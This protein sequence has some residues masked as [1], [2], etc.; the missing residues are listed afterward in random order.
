M[1]EVEERRVRDKYRSYGAATSLAVGL[2]MEFQVGRSLIGLDPRLDLISIPVVW[3]M[4]CLCAE[5]FGEQ[6]LEKRGIK[7][8]GLTLRKPY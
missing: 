4:L 2:L 3:L 6:V 5:W 8:S 7:T 1:L